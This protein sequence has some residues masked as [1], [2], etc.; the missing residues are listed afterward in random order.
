MK[1]GAQ[2]FSDK[3]AATN[4]YTGLQME[5]LAGVVVVVVARTYPPAGK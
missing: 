4:Q 5:K 1:I 2:E 3:I